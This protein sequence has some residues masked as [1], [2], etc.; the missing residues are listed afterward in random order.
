MNCK[1]CGKRKAKDRDCKFC[2]RDR[3]K[4]ILRSP[5]GCLRCRYRKLLHRSKERGWP[6]PDFTVD[7]FLNR[8]KDDE[9]FLKVYSEWVKSKFR[10]LSSPSVDRIDPTI[11]Y[12]LENIRIISWKD[13]HHKGWAED[14]LQGTVDM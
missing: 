1:K 9:G 13:N 12:L 6:V 10:K 4:N 5:E 8:F 7:D 14:R 3:A 11:P 2:H